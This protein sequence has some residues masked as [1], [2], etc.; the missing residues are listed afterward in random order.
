M[1]AGLFFI[2]IQ[3]FLSFFHGQSEQSSGETVGGAGV[4]GDDGNGT[5]IGGRKVRFR[6]DDVVVTSA[7][8]RFIV[9]FIV[10]GSDKGF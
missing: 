10:A 4:F 5:V 8:F 6:I 2:G 7:V 3:Y 1:D 9:A